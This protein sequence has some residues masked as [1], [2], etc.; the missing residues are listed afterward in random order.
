MPDSDD[1]QMPPE[2]QRLNEILMKILD[3]QYS[4]P[5]GPAVE[6][7][8]L[9]REG[10]LSPSDGDFLKSH[11]VTY[12]PHRLS[13][14]HAMDMLH[15]PTADGGCM[16]IGPSGLSPTKRTAPLRA[17]GSIVDNFL[18]LPRPRDELLLHIELTEH[19]GLG[20]SPGF[21]SFGFGSAEWRERLPAIRGVAGEFGLRPW[22]DDVVQ[23]GHTLSFKISADA[24]Q[25][26]AA[27]VALL[28]RG[29]GFNDDTEIRYS[30]GALDEA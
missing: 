18:Q 30:A 7:D 11:S 8:E 5:N 25:T 3:Y 4:L 14:Y 9:L 27:T 29:C 16:F 2:E 13:D 23:S 28:S 10:A 15:M 19:D 22:Q 6:L 12:K 21:I 24:A 17:F 20:V 26:A 1:F